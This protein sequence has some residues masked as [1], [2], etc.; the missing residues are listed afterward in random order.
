M[1]A[2]FKD[3]LDEKPG[4]NVAAAHNIDTGEHHPIR[5]LPYRLCLSWKSQVKE[6]IDTLLAAGII[7]PC[8]AGNFH[9]KE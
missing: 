8:S 1:L 2:D 3:V 7:E 9:H 4:C 6:E 5:S